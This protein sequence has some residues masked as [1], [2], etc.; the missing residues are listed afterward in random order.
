MLR[1]LLQIQP[2]EGRTVFRLGFHSFLSIGGAIFCNTAAEGFFIASYPVSWIPYV[3]LGG[4]VVAMLFATFYD[5]LQNLLK[6]V[7]LSVTTL[8]SLCTVLVALVFSVYALPKIGPFLLFLMAPACGTV[9]NLEKFKIIDRTLDA[10]SARRLISTITIFASAGSLVAGF[11][12]GFLSP[13]LGAPAMVFFGVALFLFS[14]TCVRGGE[15]KGKKRGVGLPAGWGKVLKHHFAFSII[16]VIFM[17]GIIKTVSDF[18][19][20]AAMKVQL[21]PEQIAAFLGFVR[22]VLSVVGILFQFFVVRRLMSGLGVGWS[23]TVYSGSVLAAAVAC[24]VWPTLWTAVVVMSVARLLSQGFQ[25][26]LANIVIMPLP[27]AVRNKIIVAIGGTLGAMSTLLACVG[28]MASADYV[29]WY[30]YSLPL[31]LFAL[32]GFYYGFVS[33]KGYLL[34]V[35]N[36]LRSRRFRMADVSE[37]WEQPDVMD[38]K[39]LDILHEQIKSGIPD[40]VGLALNLLGGRFTPQTVKQIEEEWCRWEDWLKEEAVRSLSVDPIP[41]AKNFLEQQFSKEAPQLQATFMRAGQVNPTEET[42][43]HLVEE[44]EP[45]VRAEAMVMMHKKKGLSSIQNHLESW[46]GSG[47]PN[48]QRAAAYVI[49]RIKEPPFWRK[50]PGLGENAPKEVAHAIARNPDPKF[51]G[52]C[53]ELLAHSKAYPYAKE[54]LVQMGAKARSFLLAAVQEGRNAGLALSVLGEF[55]DRVSRAALFE[56]L[57]TDDDDIR[58]QTI[59][60][61][62]KNPVINDE[63]IKIIRDAIQEELERCLKDREKMILADPFIKDQALEDF[64]WTAKRIFFLLSLLHPG[65]PFQKIYLSFFSGDPAQKSFALEALDEMLDAALSKKLFRVFETGDEAKKQGALEEK[66]AEN[67]LA[68]DMPPDVRTAISLKKTSFF[69]H[70]RLSS[71]RKIACYTAESEKEEK[72]WIYFKGEEAFGA[73]EAILGETFAP[74]QGGDLLRVSLSAVYKEI[75]ERFRCGADWLKSIAARMPQPKEAEQQ[76]TK[77][78]ISLD[79][80][81]EA[82]GGNAAEGMEMWERIFLLRSAP[83]FKNLE[84]EH[85]RM[86][87]EISKTV[88]VEKGKTI[89]AEGETG[90][91]FYLISSGSVEVSLKG[92][93][94]AVLNGADVFG[95]LA[96][97]TGEKRT[98][99]CKALE[100]CQ[101]LAVEQVDFLD[102]VYTHPTLVKPFSKM[103]ARR[104][105]ENRKQ[106][107]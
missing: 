15:S 8:L 97:F 56:M 78:D 102:L 76:K 9:V 103:I 88:S 27:D 14:L 5:R 53:V 70:W 51:A 60:A 34:E 42:L 48:Q 32:I 80:S 33:K 12:V 16:V 77:K 35:A 58:Y 61:L 72:R 75:F 95:E 29:V 63:E 91:C 19:L 59:K 93:R 30:V 21:P 13:V 55:D 85:L 40:K 39:A 54:A 94:L 4:A 57:Q 74:P 20:S 31:A 100:D 90:F 23:M 44:K 43:T 18:Q 96:M 49:G 82:Q 46:I 84:P 79:N 6:P 69:S 65:K 71:L 37:N 3:Y 89:V 107:I 87:G 104:V 105:L 41:E 11:G 62:S 17:M 10:R 83:L 98:A 47:D 64:E 106:Q 2:G 73:E 50:L 26:P 81:M 1:R 86:I 28:L 38:E 22:G 25:R 67:S 24:F 45:N 68:E 101:L 99:T 92:E 7:A 52:L 66:S 36:A